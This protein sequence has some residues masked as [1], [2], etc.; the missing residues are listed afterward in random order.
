MRNYSSRQHRGG[1][2]L[3]GPGPSGDQPAA[4]GQQEEQGHTLV[5]H[6]WEAS[7][8]RRASAVSTWPS[9][10][11]MCR[12]VCPAVVAR[13][14]LALFSSRSFTMFVWPMRAAQ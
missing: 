5:M 3:P 1:T 10:A 12:G 13:L 11:A 14:G 4:S 8:S 2:A 9:R 7:F 6:A